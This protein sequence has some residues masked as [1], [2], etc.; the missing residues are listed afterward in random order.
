MGLKA[1]FITVFVRIVANLAQ[2]NVTDS[3]DVAIAALVFI[4]MLE[5]RLV[6]CV[7]LVTPAQT[8]R[9]VWPE[10]IKTLPVRGRASTVREGH[11]RQQQA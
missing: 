6:L 5:G 11:P 8:A 9:R 7:Q 10:N 3:I 2:R 1:V 4:R